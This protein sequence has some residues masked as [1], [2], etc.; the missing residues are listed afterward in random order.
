MYEFYD[1]VHNHGP[2]HNAK[3]EGQE[4]SQC[5]ICCKPTLNCPI[6]KDRTI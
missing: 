2:I 1:G 6:G 3:W 5:E 4:P